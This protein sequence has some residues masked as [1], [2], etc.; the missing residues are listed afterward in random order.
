MTTLKNDEVV[1]NFDACEAKL[2]SLIDYFSNLRD[3]GSLENPSISIKQNVVTG[4]LFRNAYIKVLL[5]RPKQVLES[6]N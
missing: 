1:I 5:L 2:G 3:R 4:H 6:Q